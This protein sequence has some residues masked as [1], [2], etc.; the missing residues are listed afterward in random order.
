MIDK[1]IDN[2]VTNVVKF[3]STKPE[4][5]KVL[6]L[7]HTLDAYRELRNRI[8]SGHFVAGQRLVEADLVDSLGVSRMMVR[9]AL[10]RLQLEG[11]LTKEA[12]KSSLVRQVSLDELEEILDTRIELETYAIRQ[13]ALNINHQQRELLQHALSELEKAR[14]S[15]PEFIDRQADLHHLWLEA[16]G[17][18]YA[19][20]FVDGLSA[21]SAQTR[22]RTAMLPGRIDA[23]LTEHRAIVDAL[24]RSHPEDCERAIREHLT[25]VKEAIRQALT[26][27]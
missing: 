11:L 13:A 15:I 7:N 25:Q 2:I 5:T 26:A 9:E 24:L 12:G 20:R 6:T 4:R 18:T 14:V 3:V 8:V 19:R 16:S 17:L 21:L 10:S 22:M 23:S 27:Q 1:M